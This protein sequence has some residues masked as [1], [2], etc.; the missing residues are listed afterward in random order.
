MNRDI[1]DCECEVDML[2][3]ENRELF[4]RIKELEEEV[5]YYIELQAGEDL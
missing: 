2:I 3:K 1:K 4:E 5:Q